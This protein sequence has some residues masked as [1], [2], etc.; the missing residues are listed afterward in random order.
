[1]NNSLRR[2]LDSLPEKALELLSDNLEDILESATYFRKVLAMEKCPPVEAVVG[3][4]VV[5][6]MVEL[7]AWSHEPI[8]QLEAAWS[9][10]NIACAEVPHAQLLIQCGAIPVLIGLIANS[11]VDAVR[12]QV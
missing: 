5:P 11:P 1:M 9:I 4:G 6:R 10:T 7:L 3:A 2:N 12:E 8:I